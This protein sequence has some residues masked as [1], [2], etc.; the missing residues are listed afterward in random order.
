MVHLKYPS[1]ERQDLTQAQ[2]GSFKFTPVDEAAPSI[3]PHPLLLQQYHQS[4][5]NAG[6]PHGVHSPDIT[7]N[8]SFF[9]QKIAPSLDTSRL[10]LGPAAM[11][12]A[13]ENASTSP[14]KH[15]SHSVHANMRPNVSTTRRND[16]SKTLRILRHK[17][18]IL[19]LS[20]PK[21]NLPD[22]STQ[23]RVTVCH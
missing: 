20:I 11:R 12:A 18:S 1:M 17:L 3:Q 14:Q 13:V 5:Q 15:F 7:S 23:V 8:P 19:N 2:L 9:N 10:R 21:T 16:L 4:L 22:P 6:F